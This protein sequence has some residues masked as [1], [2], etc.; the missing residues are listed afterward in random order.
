MRL[1]RLTTLSIFS[2]LLL[3]VSLFISGVAEANNAP[4]TVGTIPDQKVKLGGGDIAIEVDGYFSD[5]DGDEL[6]FA[7]GSS[8][9]AIATVS[10]SGPTVTVSPVAEGTVTITID[11]GT[12]TD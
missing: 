1:Q 9:T 4:T 6:V 3:I 7:A 2:T 10:V 12:P 11:A 5:P 8:D